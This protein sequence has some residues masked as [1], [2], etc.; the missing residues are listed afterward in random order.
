MYNGTAPISD[1]DLFS[2]S[3]IRDP[4]PIYRQLRDA[5]PAVWSERHQVYILSR[6]QDVRTA[7]RNWQMR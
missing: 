4:Y 2:E 3:A 5:G 1:I 6:Y 7:L